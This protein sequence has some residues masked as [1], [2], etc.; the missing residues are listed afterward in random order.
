MGFA[1]KKINCIFIVVDAMF[2]ILLVA[3]KMFK[4][5]AIPEILENVHDILLLSKG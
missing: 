1:K 2:G 3:Q 5:K 4:R